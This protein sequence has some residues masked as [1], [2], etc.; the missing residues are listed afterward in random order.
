[1][2][3]PSPTRGSATDSRSIPTDALYD[4]DA[5]PGETTDVADARPDVVARL[6]AAIDHVMNERPQESSAPPV[7]PGQAA[8]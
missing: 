4:L 3:Q 8:R 2:R 5:D 6:A 1:M 7:T